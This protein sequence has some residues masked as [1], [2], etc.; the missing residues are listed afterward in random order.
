MDDTAINV[1][2]LRHLSLFR[3]FNNGSDDQSIDSIF[4]IRLSSNWPWL[5]SNFSFY[6]LLLEIE[7]HF[8]F[9]TLQV[10]SFLHFILFYSCYISFFLR[11]P[12]FFIL[13]SPNA[14]FFIINRVNAA[15]T[16]SFLRAIDSLGKWPFPQVKS[17]KS[18][19]NFLLLYSRD[20]QH[21]ILQYLF[22][23]YFPINH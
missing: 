7:E 22:L 14:V 3:Y 12:L 15:F 10:A 4:A 11:L 20:H 2:A 5:S 21:L 16:I 1:S 19:P 23:S 18:L 13:Y 9:L 17:G 8:P 6:R